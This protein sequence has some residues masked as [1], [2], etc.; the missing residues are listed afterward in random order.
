MF[1]YHNKIIILKNGIKESHTLLSGIFSLLP[2]IGTG[3]I[4]DRKQDLIY[5]RIQVFQDPDFFF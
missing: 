5:G 1:V 2:A 3:S 4:G